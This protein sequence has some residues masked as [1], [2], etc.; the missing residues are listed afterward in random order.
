MKGV[1]SPGS[2][3]L[4][5]EEAKIMHTLYWLQSTSTIFQKEL[6]GKEHNF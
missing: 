3:S 2:L 1:S 6:L 4:S 5:T